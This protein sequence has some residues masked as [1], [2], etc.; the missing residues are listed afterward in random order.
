MKTVIYN[1]KTVKTT[2]HVTGEDVR[3]QV[4]GETSQCSKMLPE[5][6]IQASVSILNTMRNNAPYLRKAKVS[7]QMAANCEAEFEA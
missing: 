5:T 1:W 4:L 7:A 2:P 3:Q 6:L